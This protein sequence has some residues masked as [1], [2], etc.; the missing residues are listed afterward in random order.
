MGDPLKIVRRA[1]MTISL[2]GVDLGYTDGGQEVN[3]D[4]SEFPVEVDQELTPVD[5]DITGESM[6]ISTVFA[7]SSKENLAVYY[8]AVNTGA[9]P[10][11]ITGNFGGTTTKQG[12]QLILDTIKSV[13]ISGTAYKIKFTFYN[14]YA[15]PNGALKYAKGAIAGVP[16][17]FVCL[18][19][20]AN[21]EGSKLGKY[22]YIAI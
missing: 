22:E 16:L 6:E 20:V 2:D 12:G 17:K 3:R 11:T 15:K 5:A 18:A 8:N 1:A 19:Q 7:E 4:Q 13:T 10:S 21:S 14:V 9:A